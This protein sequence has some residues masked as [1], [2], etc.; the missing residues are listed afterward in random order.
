MKEITEQ[1]KPRPKGLHC[2]ALTTFA[3]A[4]SRAHRAVRIGVAVAIYLASA[5]SNR[6]RVT[7]RD[8]QYESAFPGGVQY[9]LNG[10]ILTAFAS[11]VLGVGPLGTDLGRK[12]PS[13]AVV[14]G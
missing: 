7:C 5:N 1:R 8:W 6:C 9:A 11:S 12:D 13:Q 3:W 4:T 14:D 2:L 10:V